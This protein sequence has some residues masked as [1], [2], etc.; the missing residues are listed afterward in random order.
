MN[1]QLERTKVKKNPYAIIDLPNED[2][3][4]WQKSAS[5]YKG[6]WIKA[7]NY[8]PGIWSRVTP[9]YFA[10]IESILPKI[11]S[12]FNLGDS[13]I[14]SLN[15]N[16]AIAQTPIEKLSKLQK[17]P[18]YDGIKNNQLA[19]VHYLCGE[20]FGGTGL[21]SHKKT[22][23][24]RVNSKTEKNFIQTAKEEAFQSNLRGYIDKD[25]EYYELIAYCKAKPSRLFIYP[26]NVLHSAIIPPQ[27][28]LDNEIAKGR[29]TITSFISFDN[30]IT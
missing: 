7:L 13:R 21:F 2:Y 18:H 20:E 26:G 16:Y 6:D 19:I 15:S 5:F 28:K 9:Q 14:E 4:L 22:N 27:C 12:H 11:A 8:Y 17:I 3:E 25:N 10:F 30:D 24:E 29:L 23:I 1:I